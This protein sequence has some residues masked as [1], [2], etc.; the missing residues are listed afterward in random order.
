[1]GEFPIEEGETQQ[2]EPTPQEIFEAAKDYLAPEDLVD[3][4]GMDTDEIFN[5]V[6]TILECQGVDWEDLFRQHGLIE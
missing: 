6:I 2:I 1:M 3:M 5:N 4:E